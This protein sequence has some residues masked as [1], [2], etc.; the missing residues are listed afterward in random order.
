MIKYYVKIAGSVY[1]PFSVEQLQQMAAAGR[2]DGTAEVS[3]DRQRW[4]PV[5]AVIGAGF[6]RPVPSA[7]I[8]ASGAQPSARVADV[9]TKTAASYLAML[10]NRTCYPFYRTT[11]LVCTI[12]GYIIAGL[13][14]LALLVKVLWTGMSSVAIYE[15]FAALFAAVL[16][17]VFV[18]VVREIFSMYADL[19]DSTLDKHSKGT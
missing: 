8:V 12:L 4:S 17:G 2:I 9:N 15:P 11:V 7:E 19:V 13:P 16:I 18:T 5:A 3:A 14:V 1:G 6:G 10:R